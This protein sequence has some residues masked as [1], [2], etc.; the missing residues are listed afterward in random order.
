MGERPKI[1]NGIDDIR[2]MAKNKKTNRD[3]LVIFFM[4][5]LKNI[6]PK[7]C[8]LSLCFALP[9]PDYGIMGSK[10]HWQMRTGT[11]QVPNRFDTDLLKPN[12]WIELVLPY[13]TDEIYIMDPVVL[14]G[15]KEMVK[16]YKRSEPVLNLY[17][18]WSFKT[19]VNQVFKYVVSI[20]SVTGLLQD[21]S[22]RYVPN[23]CY[24]YFDNSVWS[25]YLQSKNYCAF[26][27]F[28]KV[29]DT[30]NRNNKVLPT[31]RDKTF[32]HN[33]MHKIAMNN[34]TLPKTLA[35][36]KRSNNFIIPSLLKSTE[37]IQDRASPV[38]TFHYGQQMKLKEH[39]YWRKDVQQLKSRQHWAILGRSVKSDVKPLKQKKYIPMKNRKRPKLEMYEIKELYS[40]E[41][42]INT[43]KYPSHYRDQD[44][45]FSK[46]TDPRYYK[47]K[48]NHIEI[49]SEDIKPDGF[50]LIS[51]NEPT[52]IKG[53]IHR[54]NR[55]QRKN[56]KDIIY[57][58]DVVSGFDFKQKKGSAVPV[59]ESILV[60][61]NDYEKIQVFLEKRQELTSLQLWDTLIRKAQLKETL[62][63]RY[64]HI[65][66]KPYDE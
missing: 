50:K 65:S 22:A 30:I 21:V 23:L 36:V 52:D 43:P 16:K 42:T 39:I 32:Q 53:S 29:I 46:I 41:Q 19:T 12:F 61:E 1:I 58:L 10:L 47:N 17:P 13:A 33:V 57:Y 45:K 3:I 15:E 6:L 11:G 63:I 2:I 25:P 49:Y 54:F 24:A 64:G 37:A 59:V 7:E 14:I 55:V 48:F 38:G 20:D 4:I 28:R 51:L 62:N 5:I 9:T 27:F 40:F 35:D 26:I 56:S 60:N 44:G 34:Y 66:Q 18:T 31:E 8:K